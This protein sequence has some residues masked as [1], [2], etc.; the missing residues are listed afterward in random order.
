ML[1]FAKYPLTWLAGF[2]MFVFNAL[3]GGR[4]II[5][6]VVLASVIDLG[7][8]IAVSVRMHRFTLS[9][10][11]RQTVEKM[12]VYG[13]GLVVFLVIDSL[14]AQGT[15]FDVA[16]TSGVVGIVMTF[17]ETWSFTAALLILFPNSVFLQF[18]QKAL[19]G[20]IARKLNIEESEVAKIL[21]NARRKRDE[22]G[23][24]IKKP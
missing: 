20:E 6:T 7:C 1:E 21:A 23:R 8:G 9:E 12:V 11:I 24:F 16:L 2:F 15:G 17:A 3:T 14:V 4:L 19:T 5:Y 22:K 13:L 18:M 10:L